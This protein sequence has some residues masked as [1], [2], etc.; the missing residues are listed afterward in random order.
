M[1]FVLTRPTIVITIEVYSFP[2]R[3]LFVLF[4]KVTFTEA[5]TNLRSNIP[6]VFSCI[7]FESLS[8]KT[9]FAV[10]VGATVTVGIFIGICT[11]YPRPWGIIRRSNVH[12]LLFSLLTSI[13]ICV[14]GFLIL[15]NFLE[16]L[17]LFGI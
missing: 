4:K 14:N 10:E 16:I 17:Y 2:S 5:K 3:G 12:L 7:A 13:G 8:L 15:G 9:N 1:E 11:K 6:L